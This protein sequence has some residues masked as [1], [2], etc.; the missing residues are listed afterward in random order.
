MYLEQEHGDEGHHHARDQSLDLDLA[1]LPAHLREF[2]WI[3]NFFDRIAQ[4][5]RTSRRKAYSGLIA[6]LEKARS[7]SGE[8]GEQTE[9]PPVIH[10]GGKQPCH[11][12]QANDQ[13]NQPADQP[14]LAF[15]GADV[16]NTDVACK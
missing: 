12:S 2:R 5:A 15:F 9:P 8:K 7:G 14:F 3:V 4:L 1:R 16:G 10:P 6:P 13:H 11:H